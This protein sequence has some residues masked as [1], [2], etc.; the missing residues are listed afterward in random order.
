[1]APNTRLGLRHGAPVEPAIGFDRQ[2]EDRIRLEQEIGGLSLDLEHS[3]STSLSLEYGRHGAP[4]PRFEGVASF[5]RYDSDLER[6]RDA[7]ARRSAR[8]QSFRTADDSYDGGQT[9][10]TAA[11]HASGVTVGAGLGYGTGARPVSRAGSGAEYDPDRELSGMLKRRGRISLLDDTNTTARDPSTA[12]K[13]PVQ[14]VSSDP[15][16]V[17][18]T[19]E[20]DHLLETGHI[21]DHSLRVQPRIPHTHATEDESRRTDLESSFHRGEAD[22]SFSRRK[23]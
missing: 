22:D 16:I 9:Q 7:S 6:S 20:L 10:S 2:E 21:P 12:K 3:G 13:K 17:D 23:P 15:L 1:M 18:D 5:A 19:A 14:H 4:S 11:H 8:Y